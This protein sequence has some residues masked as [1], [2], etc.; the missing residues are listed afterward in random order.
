MKHFAT[1]FAGS[2]AYFA[3][4]WFFVGWRMEHLFIY[5]LALSLY[6]FH[7][8]T[9]RFILAFG[10]F[11]AYWIIYDSMRVVPNYEVNPIHVAEPY[12][13][14]KAWFGVNTPEGRLTW[15]EFFKIHHT[16]FWDIVTGLF[17][18]NWV[19]IPLLFAFWLLR[20]DKLLF[21]KFSYA[22]VFTNLIGFCI[23]YLYPAAPPWYVEQHGFEVIHG[24]KGNAAG[25]L[26][27]DKLVCINIFAGMY[28]KNA[29]VF[30]AIPSLHSAYPVLCLLYGRRLKKTWLNVLFAVF[31]A[32]VWF[33]A[34]YSRHHYFIDVLLGGAVAVA[35][36]LAFEYLS[37]KTILK[38]WFASFA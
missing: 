31:T 18:L 29:N 20:N 10:V 24:T 4:F 2:A 30:A 11:V 16:P 6:Y 17:Y 13:I 9:R 22:F 12:Y 34:V 27:F 37:E 25:L 21:L 32:G 5:V 38:K 1:L 28:Q 19:P 33:A 23:Y 35:S 7:T 36:Y 14:E 8:T 15:N 26:E 3:W